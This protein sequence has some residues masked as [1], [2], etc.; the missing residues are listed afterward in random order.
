MKILKRRT[1]LRLIYLI[2]KKCGEPST[3]TDL[4]YGTKMNFKQLD[5][6]LEDLCE[7][8]LIESIIIDKKKLYVIT[9]DGAEA[10]LDIERVINQLD[11]K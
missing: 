7:K 11:K 1:Q 10:L 5:G 3:K 9:A 6:Y 8:K 4:A 2:L